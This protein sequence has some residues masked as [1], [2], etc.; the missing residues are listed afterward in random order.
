MCTLHSK[1]RT[2]NRVEPSAH[3]FLAE[4][5]DKRLS[6]QYL[7]PNIQ[8]IYQL[9]NIGVSWYTLLEQG[10]DVHPS[11]QVLESLAQALKLTLAEKQHLFHLSGIERPSKIVVEEAKITVMAT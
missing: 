8:P 6:T 3:R 9:A 1:P 2:G 11:H 5:S 4:C 7:R 10:H